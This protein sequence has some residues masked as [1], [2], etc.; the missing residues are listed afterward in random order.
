MNRNGAARLAGFLYLL[1]NATAIFAFYA[2]GKIMVGGDALKTAANIAAS[3]LLFRAGIVMELVTVI[4]VLVLVWALY[5]VLEPINRNVALLAVF[6]RL[7]ENVVLAVI[8]LAE[9]AAL[10]I[11]RKPSFDPK[12]LQ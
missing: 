6:W 9:F 10:A 3:E 7:A 1:T 4:L 8:I 5:V 12:Q 11:L 2:R